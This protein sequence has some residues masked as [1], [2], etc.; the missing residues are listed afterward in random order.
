LRF[1][2]SYIIILAKPHDNLP[3]ALQPLIGSDVPL[4]FSGYAYWPLHG[5]F[6]TT[7]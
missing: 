5:A 6:V 7:Y 3:A 2:R 1:Y 4:S